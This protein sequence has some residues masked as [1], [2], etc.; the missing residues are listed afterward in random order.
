[1]LAY[2]AA[3][4][5]VV[6]SRQ[7]AFGQVATEAMACGTPVVGF[8]GTGV[9]DIVDHRVNGYLAQPFDPRDLAQGMA[10]VVHQGVA[11]REAARQKV[12]R[13]F[14]LPV[15]VQQYVDL[16]RSLSSASS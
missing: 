1:V 16:Y 12:E 11:L 7:E 13:C 2:S 6:P 15:V 8:A 5:L 14:S 3:D 9:Q 4:V 10:W